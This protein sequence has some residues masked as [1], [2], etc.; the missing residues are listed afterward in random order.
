MDPIYGSSAHSVASSGV[1]LGQL[2]SGAFATL[3]AYFGES[4]RALL[5]RQEFIG[6]TAS[7]AFETTEVTQV[8]AC[9]AERRLQEN[10]TVE[11]PSVVYC[12]M[13]T[14]V[15]PGRIKLGLYGYTWGKDWQVRGDYVFY[16]WRLCFDGI[17]SWYVNQ[18][19]SGEGP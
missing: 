6:S 8:E 11:P 14:S 12:G 9:V 5:R 2:S 10:E 13:E 15:A 17:R 4:G 18:A 1:A 7:T 3:S 19:E 16:Q